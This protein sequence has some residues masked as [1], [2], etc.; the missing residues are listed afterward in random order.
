MKK[1][2]LVVTAMI[3]FVSCEQSKIGYVDNVKLLEDYQEKT[4]ID[5]SFEI[6]KQAWAKKKDSITQ[7]FRLEAQAYQSKYPNP[8]T[9]KAQE[10]GAILQQKSQFIGQ[11]LQQEEQMLLSTGQ[12]ELDS[13]VGRIKKAIKAYGKTNKY[14]YILGGGDGGAVL[15]G[16]DA[17]DLT[18]E[19]LK[20]LN[21]DYKKE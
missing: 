6:K 21:A 14:A 1:L 19:I 5:A 15:Y 20:V 13:V 11:Q 16:N 2:A 12:V 7:A 3:L 18:G 17:H 10:E 8:N 9:K 4:D